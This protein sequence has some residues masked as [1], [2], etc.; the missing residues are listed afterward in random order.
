MFQRRNRLTN[1]QRLK[2]LVWPRQG[3]RRS[4]LYIAHRLG[5]LPGTPYRVAAGFA[6]GAAVSF[7]PF[8][9]LHF[10]LA[11]L[12][13]LLL[14]GHIL[15]S[16]IGTVVGNP[17]TFP[18]IWAW[19]YSLGWWLIG[20]PNGHEVSVEFTLQYIG[21]N[22]M[23]VG[24]PMTVGALPTAVV[25]WCIAFVPIYFIVYEYQ[26]ARQWRIRRKATKARKQSEAA[27]LSEGQL[28][29]QA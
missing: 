7:T 4:T 29:K 12:L 3:W 11:A 25:V 9:G 14:R 19:T 26:R 8:I 28:G 16:A 24:W 13:S 22:I 15:A 23:S 18:F 21:E 1:V 2:E 5:R 20:S 6:C 27:G 17:W 10:V